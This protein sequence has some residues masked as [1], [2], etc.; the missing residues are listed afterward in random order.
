M[1]TKTKKLI[2]LILGVAMLMT[3][4][5]MNGAFAKSSLG[6]LEGNIYY[7]KADGVYSLNTLEMEFDTDSF[8]NGEE[9]VLALPDDFKVID[10][11]KTIDYLNA[12]GFSALKDISYKVLDIKDNI[13]ENTLNI[14]VE[15]MGDSDLIKIICQ[16]DYLGEQ[17]QAFEILEKEIN[18]GKYLL[19]IPSKDIEQ[20]S[21]QENE[22]LSIE[23]Q[24][25]NGYNP[26][27]YF[28]AS[29]FVSGK[30][31]KLTPDSFKEILFKDNNEISLVSSGNF[32]NN[33]DIF[34][35]R[36]HLGAVYVPDDFDG[37]VKIGID[38]SQN[39]S[40]IE[41]KVLIGLTP[42]SVWYGNIAEVYSNNS[43]GVNISLVDKV[44]LADADFKNATLKLA[45]KENKAGDLVK[46]EESLKFILPDNFVWDETFLPQLK[47]S[48]DLQNIE[49]IIDGN[50][51]ILKVNKKS[52]QPIS[53]NLLANIASTKDLDTKED[54]VLKIE[55]ES[56]SNLA[57]LLI[58]Y[59]QNLPIITAGVLN[60][61]LGD[62]SVLIENNSSSASTIEL[63][64]P[65]EAKWI[66]VPSSISIS[67]STQKIKYQGM[68]DEGRKII[69]S[70]PSGNYLADFSLKDFGVVISPSFTGKLVCDV[71]STSTDNV[72]S[73]YIAKVASSSTDTL[74]KVNDLEEIKGQYE[75]YEEDLE[76]NIYLKI[77]GEKGFKITS[78]GIF[79]YDNNGELDLGLDSI[80]SIFYI[81]K[82]DYFVNGNL[83]TMDVAPYLD[84]NGRTL[85]PVRYIVKA[86]GVSEENIAWDNIN[87]KV[88]LTWEDNILEIGIGENKFSLNGKDVP[89]DTASILKEGR[90][91]LPVRFIGE[92]LGLNIGFEELSQKVII[93]GSL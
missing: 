55:G 19:Y 43:R 77:G 93:S 11:L 53:L 88:K 17:G 41:G 16:Y 6:I 58:G 8:E 32:D 89:M 48:F 30:S 84:E 85:I 60:Q 27:N 75:I 25:N 56:Q 13:I 36:L 54:I 2:S 18:L 87:Q 79:P 65:E 81:G 71:L 9:A 78:E 26:W 15:S 57:Q 82:N 69:Y 76:G 10:Y 24:W 47:S 67:N 74:V 44:Y 35:F 12:N 80:E 22:E 7:V 70:I 28:E 91:M 37:L 34:N 50:E 86:F 51:L 90:T 33:A 83:N 38:K 64:L 62:I 59:Y 3:F 29:D 45:I 52:S 42:G 63:T 21:Y 39:S 23:G 20:I 1:F 73:L 46:N 40:F 68:K 49:A 61:K 66:K 92:A 31:N 5:P 14:R 4:L 72:E